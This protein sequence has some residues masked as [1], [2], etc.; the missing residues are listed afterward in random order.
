MKHF[1]GI[2]NSSLD[3]KVHII[4]EL[5]NNINSFIISN[6]F[7]GF[8]NLH[9]TIKKFKNVSFAFELPHGPLV[10]Y[11]RQKGYNLYSI[12]PLKIKRFKESYIVSGNKNDKVDAEAIAHYLLR[13]RNNLRPLMFNSYD[14][15]RLKVFTLSHTRLTKEHTRY[16]NRL[17]F[18]LRQYFPLYTSL[19]SDHSLKIQL[20]M[21]IA[22]PKHSDLKRAS[23]EDLIHF[24]KTNHYRNPKYINKVLNNIEG[25]QQMI[26][27]EVEEALQYEARALARML[28]TIKIELKCIQN[29]MNDIT[30]NHRLGKYFKSL[31]G[32][33]NIFSC[34]L[35]SLFGD[36]KD[37]YTDANGIQCLFGTA[38]RN[39]QSGTYH[40]VIMR[41]ACNKL[42]KSVLYQFSFSSI[43]S[44]PWAREYY[45][46][47]RKKGKKH[48]VAVRALSNKW[49]KIIY[50][51]WKDEIIYQE[52]KKIT[53]AA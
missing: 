4:D 29:K 45:Y 39:Y 49:V 13:Y 23:R 16:S 18:I 47:Q 15:E 20:K 8:E 22:Y 2:D 1:I 10:D 24:L 51:L 9:N 6:D 48:S 46:N 30:N 42:A 41:K 40:K 52:E 33:G 38:P 44:S 7:K 14:I 43:K 53:S 37:R 17:L 12:N 25:Y 26:S 34:K 35:L 19:F 11:L 31:P 28:I 36:N 32:S 50:K 3:H 21:L 5:G 27:P